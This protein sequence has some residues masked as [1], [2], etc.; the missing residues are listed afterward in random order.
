MGILDLNAD[1]G[2]EIT[3]DAGLLSVVTSAN[4]ACGAHAG[5]AS[6]MRAVCAGAAER[7]VVVG[8][9]VSYVDRE[10]F[11]RVER[12]VPPGLLAEQVEQ[13]VRALVEAA[14]GSGVRVAYLKCHGALYHRTR[15]D[16]DQAR[17]VLAGLHAALDGVPPAAVA[18][19]GMPGVLR[20]LAAAAGH[21]VVAEGFPDRGY[22]EHGGLLARGLPGAVLDDDAAVVAQALAL[23][24]GG[25]GH[26]GAGVRSL[27]VHGDHP[28]AL[29]R[30]RSV[31]RALEAAGH[32][33]E[34][35]APAG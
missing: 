9:Q 12:D 10:H 20:D 24:A 35:F 11:G 21:R 7:G 27:C 4:V 19:L 2:E 6:I 34:A 16:A 31:R 30:A 15:R 32:R 8:A 25:A 14:A 3:D 28:G 5:S 22:D 33:V 13:Q 1:L 29:A 17:A 23:A 26:A 18:V